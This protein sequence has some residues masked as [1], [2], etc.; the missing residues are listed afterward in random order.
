[1][2]GAQRFKLP[3]KVEHNYYTGNGGKG[4][5][6][7]MFDNEDVDLHDE[8]EGEIMSFIVL[9]VNL[10]SVEKPCKQKRKGTIQRIGSPIAAP[11][12]DEEEDM[13]DL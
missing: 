12:P 10:V 6:V 11:K 3:F 1:L 9:S 5:E 4:W 8:L 7:Q 2:S 13:A